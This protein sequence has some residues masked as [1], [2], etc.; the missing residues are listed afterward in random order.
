MKLAIKTVCACAVAAAMSWTPLAV[1][2]FAYLSQAGGEPWGLNGNINA[3]DDVFGAGNWDRLDFPTAV[4]NGLWDHDFIFIDGG[5]G[6]TL[7][8]LDFVNANRADME[9]WVAAGG[10]LV[11]GAARWSNSDPFDL[12]FGVTL[13]DAGSELGYAFDTSHPVYDGPFGFAAGDFEGDS[14]A[15]DYLTG[16]FTPL[17]YGESGESE[18]LLAE[19]S[20]GSGHVIFH[21]LTLPFFGEDEAWSP[22]CGVFHR[23]LLFYGANV[24][25]PGALALLALAGLARRRRR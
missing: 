5:D 22:N 21:G 1:G 4:G 11:I 20:Y 6:A 16:D 14:L 2:G 8:F 13:N 9:N 19:K 7:E 10:R 3:M 15:H 25:A 24:P 23:N 18:V 12:G 17:M